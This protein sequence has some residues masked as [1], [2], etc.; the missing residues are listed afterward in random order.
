MPNEPTPSFQ[1]GDRVIWWKQ[2]PGGGY[3]YPVAATVL[4]VTANRVQIAGDDD[5]Q[6]VK[7]SV[8]PESL[9]KEDAAQPERELT[10]KQGQYLAFIY[11]YT[12]IN[13]RPPSEADMQRMF[14][15][16]APSVHNMLVRLEENG[17]IARTPGQAR[18][19]RVLVPPDRLPPLQGNR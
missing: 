19:I 16:S 3:A 1:V 13:D 15:V 7:R 17:W 9:Q 6:I 11:N 5:G 18:S 14:R 10:Y 12:A 4:K 8:T 2:I